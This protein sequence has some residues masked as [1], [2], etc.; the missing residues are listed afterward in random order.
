MMR[1]DRTSHHGPPP[2]HRHRHLPH[3]SPTLVP[4]RTS[5]LRAMGAVDGSS[6]EL[7]QDPPSG[8]SDAE[9]VE[10]RAADAPDAPG[11]YAVLDDKNGVQYIGSVELPLM[12]SHSPRSRPV[13]F[14]LESNT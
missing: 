5:L 14:C 3:Q 2:S 8:F 4:K 7:Q 1:I 9:L 12:S 10:L 11:V 13:N 6:E